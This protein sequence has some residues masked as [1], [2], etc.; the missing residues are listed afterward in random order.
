MSTSR[1]P[2]FS[3]INTKEGTFTVAFL[4]AWYNPDRCAECP[5]FKQKPPD[6][7]ARRTVSYCECMEAEPEEPCEI[8]GKRY[9][10]EGEKNRTET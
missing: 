4:T 1:P 10:H 5:R 7:E 9:T 2:S 8:T 6:L 3:A